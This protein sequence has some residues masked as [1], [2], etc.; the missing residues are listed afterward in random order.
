MI[1]DWLVCGINHPSL[2][3]CLLAEPDLSY[4]KAVKLAFNAKTAIQSVKELR[5]KQDSA[6]PSQQ[7]V[8]NANHV[9]PP[10]RHNGDSAPTCYRCGNRGQTVAKSVIPESLAI[11]A[12]G[13]NLADLARFF[14]AY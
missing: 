12:K 6:A 8:H 4:A 5:G 13:E 7:P 11:F 9:T 3:I 10:S 2:Q 14:G 1:W